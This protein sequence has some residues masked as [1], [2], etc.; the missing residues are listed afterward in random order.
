MFKNILIK[1]LRNPFVI[2][3][4]FFDK[5][6]IPN[7]LCFEGV[8]VGEKSRFVGFPII[9]LS[10]NG[11][12]IIG[13]SVLINNRQDSNPASLPHRTMLA[14]ISNE[15]YIE[16]GDETGISGASIVAQSGI[17]IGK[18]VLI[19]SGACIWDTDFHPL[20]AEKRRESMTRDALSKPIEIGNE[21]FIGARAII[22]KGVKIGNRAV[23]GAGAVVTKNVKP[24]EIVAGNPAK[25]VVNIEKLMKQ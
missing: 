19:G 8:I 15:S 10:P 12:I 3:R 14:T 22:L 17:K 25:K 5:I 9:K 21:V 2:F 4:L 20:D 7:W 24:G 11:K 18:R 23:I 13:R 1:L 6:V 16:I